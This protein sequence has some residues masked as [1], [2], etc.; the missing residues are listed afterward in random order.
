MGNPV[1]Q[2]STI[3]LPKMIDNLIHSHGCFALRCLML[4]R[5]GSNDV[6]KAEG[7]WLHLFLPQQHLLCVNFKPELSW[8]FWCFSFPHSAALYSVYLVWCLFAFERLL[9][10]HVDKLTLH[11]FRARNCTHLSIL[12]YH[13]FQRNYSWESKKSHGY[14]PGGDTSQRRKRT[15]S[16]N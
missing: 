3:K 15:V 8:S 1:P 9:I 12:E 13:Q 6:G 7:E 2:H 10:I 5:L 16:S 14:S 4:T 11:N